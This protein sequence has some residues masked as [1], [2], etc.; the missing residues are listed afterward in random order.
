M[1]EIQVIIAV[2]YCSYYFHYWWLQII[3]YKKMD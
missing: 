2:W 3:I 1:I